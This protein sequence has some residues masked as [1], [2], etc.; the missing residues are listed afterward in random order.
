MTIKAYDY[1]VLRYSKRRTRKYGRRSIHDIIKDKE[2]NFGDKV[3]YIRH[4]YVYY[5]GNYEYFHDE[6]GKSNEEKAKLNQLIG[7][8]IQRLADPSELKVVNR[9]VLEWQRQRKLLKK[10]MLNEELEKIDSK[11]LKNPYE[12]KVDTW[13]NA[14]LNTHDYTKLALIREYLMNNS[15][16][17]K[18]EDLY[19][20][21]YRKLKNKATAWKKSQQSESSKTQTTDNGE[22]NVETI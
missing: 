17:Y 9:K 19:H 18:D 4:H 7:L 22:N 3:D 1:R 8:I 14:L 15:E 6:K 2:L 21:G 16:L 12:I 5:D 11:I 13:L 10:Q 20:Y